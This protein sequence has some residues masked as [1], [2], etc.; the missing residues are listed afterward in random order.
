MF[1]N[2]NQRQSKG[3]KQVLPISTV[4]LFAIFPPPLNF[5]S[6][7]TS[8]FLTR[9]YDL[10]GFIQNTSTKCGNYLQKLFTTP[11]KYRLN[12]GFLY[13]IPLD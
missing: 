8:L 11:L 4:E 12:H 1:L 10:V 5:P 2:A 6:G 7:T 3:K 9:W 13:G